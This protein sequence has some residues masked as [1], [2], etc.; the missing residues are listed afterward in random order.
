M[1]LVIWDLDETLWEG[2]I[3]YGETIKLKNEA[4]EVLKQ[5]SKLDGVKQYVCT[6]NKMENTMC[7]LKNTNLLK[8]FDGIKASTGIEKD[9][10]V[11]EILEETG[12]SPEETIF[13]DDTSFN[14]ALVKAVTRCN[15][16]YFTDLFEIFKYLDTDRLKLMNEQRDR[17]NAEQKWSGTHKDFLMS[18]KS[19]LEIKNAIPADIKRISDLANRT[20]E[21]NAA[22]NRYT[23]KEIETF[24]KGNYT[25]LVGRLKDKFGDYGLIAETIVE[26]VNDKMIIL[27]F[28]VSCRTMGRGVGSQLM[29]FLIAHAMLNN[30]KKIQG[31]INTTTDNFRMP[32]LYKKFGFKEVKKIR[33]TIYFEREL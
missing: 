26:T 17:F 1:K 31:I 8:Y 3:Y 12:C 28:T 9:V 7:I 32:K 21:L 14:T 2:T 16:D 15:V 22:R 25:V 27:D 11:L 29:E 19:E 5:I 18:V 10:M 24:I 6:H 13:I 30:M 23:E 4:E 33:D 20:N